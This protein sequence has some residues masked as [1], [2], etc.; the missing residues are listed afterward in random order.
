MFISEKK[1][2]SQAGELNPIPPGKR[3]FDIVHIYHL[4][5]FVTTPRKNNYVL[6]LIDNLT[7]YAYIRPVED[8][9]ANT[10]VR[11]VE[12]FI[13]R[14]SAPRRLVTDKGTS[15]TSQK[16]QALCEKYKMKHTLNSSRHPQA[17]G[18]IERLNQTILPLIKCSFDEDEEDKWDLKLGKI[19][20][21]LKSTV[22]IATGKTPYEALYGYLPRF[23][24]CGT[25]DLTE[26]CEKYRLPVEVQDKIIVNIGKKQTE[27]KD[28]YVAR[29]LKNV[30]F[31]CEDIVFIKR[32]PI[33]TGSSTKLQKSFDGPL[34]VVGIEPSGTYRVKKL[35]IS[36]DKGFETTTH[37]SELK[38]WKRY[39]GSDSEH[40][41]EE[42]KGNEKVDEV[43]EKI[44]HLCR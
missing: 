13:L 43:R 33:A 4:G 22:I 15:F 35:N 28:R 14:F 34:V 11:K 5:P 37:V 16:F 41:S 26:Q 17:N 25:K 24:D 42:E 27:Y 18:L 8:V 21:G 29:R 38:I 36:H 9:K 31:Q 2:A 23:E 39:Q 32:D 1:S 10:T 7:K 20:S 44:D 19:E 40:E 6:S 3:P 30:K 12:E